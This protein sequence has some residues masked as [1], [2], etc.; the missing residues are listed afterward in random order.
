MNRSA[1]MHE[2]LDRE[3]EI[4]AGSEWTFGLVFA[5]VFSVIGL[6]PLIGGEAIRLWALTI[7]GVFALAAI[8]WPP[9]LGPLNQIWFQFGQLLHGIVNPLVLGLLF[10]TAVTPTA[11]FMRLIGKD[12]LHRRFEPDLDSYWIVRQPVGSEPSSMKNQ[13]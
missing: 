4:K 2:D 1:A 9:V 8:V 5:V 12:P 3:S 10:Y 11:V 7:A 6:W 13:F